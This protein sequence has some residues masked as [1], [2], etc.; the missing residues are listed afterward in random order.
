MKGDVPKK[1]HDSF[2][3]SNFLGSKNSWNSVMFFAFSGVFLPPISWEVRILGI[4]ILHC[5]DLR[6]FIIK[7]TP[8][9]IN[10]KLCEVTTMQNTVK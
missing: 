10:T 4:C 6:V 2:F 9:E 5:V 7:L 1:D 8:A 3:V